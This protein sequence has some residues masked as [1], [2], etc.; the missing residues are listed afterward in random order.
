[1]EGNK[2]MSDR[3]DQGSIGTS[4]L[5]FLL[6]AAVGATVAVLY[7]PQAGSQTRAQIADQAAKARDKASELSQQVSGKATELS[8]Q[9]AEKA[10]ELSQQVAEKAG[11]VRKKVAST[12]HAPAVAQSSVEPEAAAPE[13]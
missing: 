9:V 7:A 1:M 10:S 6:G 4:L 5:I 3:D 8:H 12:L 11:D 13:A 2:V